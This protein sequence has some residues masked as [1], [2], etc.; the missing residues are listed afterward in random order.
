MSSTNV[1]SIHAGTAV[2]AVLIWVSQCR[3]PTRRLRR[4]CT[5]DRVRKRVDADD[6]LIDR[7]VGEESSTGTASPSMLL[8]QVA[9]DAQERA[10]SAHFLHARRQM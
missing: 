3:P 9:F 1:T 6:E 10:R 4:L 2:W 5:S 8:L 7:G